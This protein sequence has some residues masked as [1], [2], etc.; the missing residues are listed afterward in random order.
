MRGYFAFLL[1]QRDAVRS[2]K[3]ALDGDDVDS[4]QSLISLLYFEF[5][6]LVFAERLEAFSD[7]R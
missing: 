7:D 6:L 4:L 1:Q 5:Y 3:G 2:G